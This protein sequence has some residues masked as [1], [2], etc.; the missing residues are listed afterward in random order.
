MAWTLRA[1][2]EQVN[3]VVLFTMR[4]ADRPGDR[5]IRDEFAGW[6][7]NGAPVSG[8]LPRMACWVTKAYFEVAKAHERCQRS[9][10]LEA[11]KRRNIVYMTMYLQKYTG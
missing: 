1:H 2:L 5:L 4:L 3:V 6:S 8:C 11:V 7:T 9:A 10:L